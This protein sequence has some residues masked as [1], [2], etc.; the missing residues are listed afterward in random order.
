[1]LSG[2]RGDKRLR[3]KRLA[4]V[5]LTRSLQ[6]YVACGGRI[7]L[8]S[9]LH[10]LGE[11]ALYCDTDSVIF[12]QKTDEPPLI[13]YGDALGDMTSELSRINIFQSLLPGAP[14]TTLIYNVIL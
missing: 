7:H 14:R 2:L 4:C 9:Y 5:T 8:Y 1:V 6:A 11:R 10:K 3:S 12:V 13:E